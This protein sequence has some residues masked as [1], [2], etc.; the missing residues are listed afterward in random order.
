MQVS[1]II[2]TYNRAPHLPETLLSAFHQTLPPKE[3]ILVDDGSTDETADVVRILRAAYPQWRDRLHYFRQENQGKSVALNLGLEHATGDWIAYNDS[4]DTWWPNKLE[5]QSRALARHGDC[6]A[7]F[8]D[9]RFVNNPALTCTAF[10]EAGK[11]FSHETGVIADAARYVVRAPHGIYMQTVLVRR[12][13]MA[14]VGDFDPRFRVSQDTDFLFRLGMSTRLCFVNATL[15]DIDRMATRST[16][17]TTEFTRRS[18]PRLQTLETMYEKWLLLVTG[19]RNDLR[20]LV[21][22]RLRAIRNEQAN[23]HLRSGDVRMARRLLMRAL[24]T[25]F[26]P[27]LLTK[28]VAVA[29]FPGWAQR[30]QAVLA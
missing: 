22:Q 19:K 28:L 6:G 8:T 2:P 13:V 29:T 15:V 11:H 30:R 7:C 4:D 9:V 23:Y 20:V 26:S 14:A 3:V 16:G 10:G 5:L 24:H 1:V 18:W 21:R 27:V 17:L 12:D 25:R